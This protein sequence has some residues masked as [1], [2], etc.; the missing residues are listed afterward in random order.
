MRGLRHW[1]GTHGA[2]LRL[3]VRTTVGGLAAFGVAAVL[4]LP[5]GYW[6]VLTA[7]LVIQ[8]SLGGSVKATVDRLTGTIVGAVYGGL[9]AFFVP[10]TEFGGRGLALAIALA[11]LALCAALQPSF[12][13]APVTAIIVLM[14]PSNVS[15]AAPVI[16]AFDRIV[17]IVLG[18]MVGL[19]TALLVLPAR[20]HGI[21]TQAAA[22]LLDL[23][24]ALL[25]V[26]L[27][28]LARPADAA[29]IARLQASI[30]STQ[31]Q[32]EG[33]AAEA[34]QERRS[35]LTGDFDPDPLLRTLLRLRHDF[36]MVFRAAS[37]PLPA[38]VLLLLKPAIDE[39]AAT[40]AGFLSV[41]A[42][43]LVSRAVAPTL[44]SVLAALDDY[45][46]RVADLR[47][48]GTMRD[49]PGDDVG[50]IFALGFAFEQLR[51]DLGDV[52]ARIDDA[53]LEGSSHKGKGET[54]SE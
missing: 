18:S 5:Q 22:R 32:L 15:H 19:L 7:V 6:A 47:R 48:D 30:R 46:V 24:A 42:T 4:N 51:R 54:V 49:L 35:F 31:A 12:R 2:E 25:P 44:A 34:R 41:A 9:V 52:V 43:A 8:V 45:V 1:V 53:A 40:T 13:I 20:A 21:M 50:R 14:S 37:D 27:D 29:D 17:E 26:L 3:S 16:A 38:P 33:V 28:G 11:P 23:F 10:H 36:V 39:V